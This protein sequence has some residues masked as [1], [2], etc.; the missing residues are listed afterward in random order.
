MSTQVKTL[1][2]ALILIILASGT[3]ILTKSRSVENPSVSVASISVAIQV[4]SSSKSVLSSSSQVV[5]SSSQSESV[6]V[7]EA[8]K[9]QT[10]PVVEKP[11]P[12]I[13]AHKP[14]FKLFYQFN[15]KNKTGGQAITDLDINF[16]NENIQDLAN[17]YYEEIKN[18]FPNNSHIVTVYKFQKATEGTYYIELSMQINPLSGEGGISYPN[19]K[20]YKF[21]QTNRHDGLFEEIP[22]YTFPLITD[23]NQSL[24]SIS[25][26][27]NS[28]VNI[29][30]FCENCHD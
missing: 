15:D 23:S 16:L 26:Q 14:N 7:V 19:R 29:I 8:P 12:I 1:I 28:S 25:S 2:V 3:Y 11:Q 5:S 24:N 20:L 6:K 27:P 17:Y 10:S 22:S 9:V 21:T 4:S 30:D 13:E 18:L